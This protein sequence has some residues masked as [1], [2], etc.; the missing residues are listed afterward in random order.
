[1]MGQIWEGTDGTLYDESCTRI[2]RN[3][4]GQEGQAAQPVTT[5]VTHPVTVACKACPCCHPP[6]HSGTQPLSHSA[7]HL[8]T[9]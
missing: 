7:T 5:S 6:T 9:A 4:A 1:M 8:C 3:T 2:S